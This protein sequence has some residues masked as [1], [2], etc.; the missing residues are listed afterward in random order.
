LCGINDKENDNFSNEMTFIAIGFGI[1]VTFVGLGS[2]VFFCIKK[3]I[4]KRNSS[5]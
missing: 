4:E 5:L 2:T 1:G 3:I